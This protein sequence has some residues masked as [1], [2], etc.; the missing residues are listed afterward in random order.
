[1]TFQR[2]AGTRQIRMMANGLGQY[3]VVVHCA[4]GSICEYGPFSRGED[5]S[6]CIYDSENPTYDSY[7]E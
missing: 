6:Q 4:D 2:I 7:D 5:A 3:F 1:M